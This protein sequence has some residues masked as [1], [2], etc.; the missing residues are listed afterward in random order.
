MFGKQKGKKKKDDS[1]EAREA[2]I[3]LYMER[4]AAEQDIWTGVPLSQLSDENWK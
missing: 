4:V 3:A 2:R 1:P